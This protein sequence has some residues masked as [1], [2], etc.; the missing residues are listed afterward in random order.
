MFYCRISYEPIKCFQADGR[1]N[2]LTYPYGSRPE[3]RKVILNSTFI[4]FLK[5]IL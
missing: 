5:I 3:I 4:T 2:V 1:A